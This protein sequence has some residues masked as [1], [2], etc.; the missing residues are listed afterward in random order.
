MI[1][2]KFMIMLQGARRL[3]AVTASTLGQ[4]FRILIRLLS[5]PNAAADILRQYPA[6]GSN[7][8]ETQCMDFGFLS[9]IAWHLTFN[10]VIEQG[11]WIL[12]QEVVKVILG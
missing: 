4:H 9:N 12:F 8:S 5:T 10:I 7:T 2:E 3:R 11:S 6:L 1:L